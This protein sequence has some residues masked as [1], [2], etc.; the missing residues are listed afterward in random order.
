PEFGTS[1]KESITIEQ[2]LIHT[3]GLIPDNALRDYENG[4]EEAFKRI[5]ELTP[6]ATP[7]ERFIYSDVNFLVL[8]EL[9]R[10]VTGQRIDEFA[11][12]NI[13]APLGMN[14]TG[15]VPDESLAARAAPTE[16]RGDRW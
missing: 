14:D 8:A 13:F 16:R 3:S 11:R 1:G 2:L 4:Y 10:R 9:V 12:E 7:G 5:Y 15:Y 6:T